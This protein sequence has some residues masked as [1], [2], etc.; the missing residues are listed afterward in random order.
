MT[1]VRP[2]IRIGNGFDIHRFVPDGDPKPL[3]LG[4]VHFAGEPGLVAHSDGDAIAHACTDAILG[5][6]GLGDI[7]FRFPDTDPEWE[8]ADSVEMLLA[9]T[10]M[11]S[12]TGWQVINI[13]CSV[14]ASQPKLSPK[15]SEME[16]ILSRA[17]G[18]PVTIKGRRPE[19]IGELGDGVGLCCFASAL[20]FSPREV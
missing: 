14:V 9:A 12:K 2:R 15:R 4:G 3:V 5:P 18:A 8:G 20:L 7:G 17:V 6:A 10:Q 11:A 19:G 13:D 16:R 1:D